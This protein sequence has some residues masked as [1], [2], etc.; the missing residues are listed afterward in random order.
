MEIKCDFE[1]GK[2]YRHAR[3]MDVDIEVLG[4]SGISQKGISL[5]VTWVSQQSRRFIH[6]EEILI[7][8]EQYSNWKKVEN[9][10]I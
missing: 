3:S 1:V 7:V 2:Y 10:N 4:I 8:P 6:M 9:E 5:V